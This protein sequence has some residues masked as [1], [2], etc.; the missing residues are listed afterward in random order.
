M[1]TSVILTSERDRNEEKGK[2][3]LSDRGLRKADKRALYGLIKSF[4]NYMRAS[5]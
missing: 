4:S 1:P 2:L 3:Y 5:A